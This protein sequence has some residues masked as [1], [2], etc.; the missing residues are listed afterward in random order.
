M[1]KAQ[2]LRMKGL[3]RTDIKT[4]ADKLLVFG[5][6]CSLADLRTAVAGIIE[7]RMTD[8]VHMHPDLM[9]PAG[10]QAAFHHSHIAIAF[11]HTVMRDCM[12][13]FVPFGI[14]L[15]AE[16]VIR[17]AADIAC[18]GPL[19]LLDIAPDHCDI[20]SLDSMAEELPCQI[21]LG[22]IILRHHQKSGSIH[23]NPVHQHTHSVILCIRTLG[24][25]QMES[26][27]I[28]KSPL[29]MT[30]PR[31]NHHTGR[32]V[33]DQKVIIL[34]YYVE[35]DILRK[36]LE[37]PSFVWHHKADDIT[38]AHYHIGLGNFV[39][40]TDIAILYCTLHPVAGSVHKMAG[41]ILVNA[42]RSLPH[43][44]IEPEMLEH[45]LLI[46]LHR[47]FITGSTLQS[48]VGRATLPY[49]DILL[50]GSK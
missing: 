7:E 39:S 35:R 27:S 48:Q 9:S 5:I 34:I 21:E 14:N 10:L 36:H 38:W 31:V 3:P 23:I 42:K 1:D 4:V 8:M 50:T 28:D 44:H 13:A 41:H 19:V 22:I 40:E 29:E 2:S 45:P 37:T 32:F 33:Y 30:V 25:T 26:K 16:T 20:L 43:I 18:N 15:E 49:L 17:V 12:L 47:G 46:I 11:K 24:N 6:D